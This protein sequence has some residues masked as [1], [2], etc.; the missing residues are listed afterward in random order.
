MRNSDAEVV[1]EAAVRISSLDDDPVQPLQTRMI[2][3]LG[4]YY[5]PQGMECYQAALYFYVEE[6]L[7]TP[8]L[9]Q[10]PV[11]EEVVP[12]P[13][14]TPTTISPAEAPNDKAPPPPNATSN[15]QTPTW[16][17]HHPYS[18]PTTTQNHPTWPP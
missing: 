7:E 4:A 14:T 10:S 5:A 11:A 1:D 3:I 12:P 9:T 16:P 6:E 15:K 13:L 17:V 8:S 18:S 2:Q